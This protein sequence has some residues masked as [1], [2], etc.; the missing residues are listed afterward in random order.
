MEH[1]KL[2][3]PITIK[4]LKISNRT[5]MPAMGLLY[6]T[7]Y[8]MNDRLKA[9]YLE[10]ARGGIGLMTIGPL[11]FE[12]AGAAPFIVGLFDDTNVPAPP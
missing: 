7:D 2:F 12:R 3:E 11:G 9:F 8:N 5:M 1:V 6:T 10:R 4:G